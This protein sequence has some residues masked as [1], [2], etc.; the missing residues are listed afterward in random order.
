M[1]FAALPN[2]VFFAVTGIIIF[3]ASLL[4][5]L[6][7]LPGQLWN[8]ALDE[9]N[10]AAALIVASLVLAISWIIAAAVH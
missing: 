3:A 8:R 1:S 9:G 7:V 4:I 5:L 2:A 6:R 10:M